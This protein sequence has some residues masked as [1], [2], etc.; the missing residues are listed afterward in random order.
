MAKNHN[1]VKGLHSV[2]DIFHHNSAH[3]FGQVF[4]RPTAAELHTK[5]HNLWGQSEEFAGCN[6]RCVGVSAALVAVGRSINHCGAKIANS[7]EFVW[8][9]MGSSPSEGVASC[10][11]VSECIGQ[12]GVYGLTRSGAESSS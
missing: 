8:R 6:R 11:A 9:Q 12:A 10:L 2:M 3:H 7:L 4:S 1:I 5:K